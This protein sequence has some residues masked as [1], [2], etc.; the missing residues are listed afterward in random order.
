MSFVF[1]RG[2]GSSAVTRVSCSTTEALAQA[3]SCSGSAVAAVA[4]LTLRKGSL[5]ILLPP[6]LD[7]VRDFCSVLTR[8]DLSVPTPHFGLWTDLLHLAEH[9]CYREGASY[10]VIVEQLTQTTLKL[11]FAQ[12]VDLRE[13]RDGLL[14]RISHAFCGLHLQPCLACRYAK[15]WPHLLLALSF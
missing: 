3:R 4:T 8:A 9:P 2:P 12:L 11:G 13:Q 1:G 15:S 5:T 7:A 14:P 6:S 10:F